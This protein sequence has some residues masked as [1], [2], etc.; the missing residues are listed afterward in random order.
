MIVLVLPEGE[1]QT[2]LWH[3]HVSQHVDLLTTVGGATRRESTL[4][5]L[6]AWARS[7][8]FEPDT[9]ILIHDGARPFASHALIDRLLDGLERAP[10]AIPSLPVTDTLKTLDQT[11]IASGPDRSGLVT[12]QTPQAFHGDTILEAHRAVDAAQPDILFTDDA[13]ITE[14]AGHNC[15]A[16]RGDIDNIKITTP[17]DWQRAEAIL[18]QRERRM[19]EPRTGI[20]YDVHRLVPG[21]GVWLCGHFIEH[22]SRLDGH[23]DADV[24]LHALTDALLGAIGEGDIGTHFPLRSAM[25]RRSFASVFGARRRVGARSRRQDRQCRCSDRHR[26]TENRTAPRGHGGCNGR[27]APNRAKPCFSESHH[28]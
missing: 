12:V 15:V 22:H 21:D 8:A 19:L 26:A 6:E 27:D 7:N 14:W 28:K 11:V 20:G 5:G 10:G 24:G 2:A 1:D 17:D 18:E 25:E 3:D 23:S 9:R 13:S 16:V 4:A